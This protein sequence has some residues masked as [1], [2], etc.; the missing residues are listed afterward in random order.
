MVNNDKPYAIVRFLENDTFSEAPSKLV[1]RG[2]K[3]NFLLVA[4]KNKKCHVLYS[5]SHNAG[6]YIVAIVRG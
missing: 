1:I 3:Q 5:K 4:N 6:C 2:R